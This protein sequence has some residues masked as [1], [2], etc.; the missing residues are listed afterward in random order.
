[1]RQN[2]FVFDHKEKTIEDDDA[3]KRL[4]RV[5][6]N[7]TLIDRSQLTIRPYSGCGHVVLNMMARYLTLC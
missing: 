7:T 2:Y 4:Q 5:L 3:D 6:D 1:M